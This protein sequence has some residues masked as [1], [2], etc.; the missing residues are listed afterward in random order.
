MNQGT[1]IGGLVAV[2]FDPTGSYLLTVSHSGR[3][4]FSTKTW[5]RLARDYALAYPVDGRAIGI[6]PIEGLSVVV[7]ELDTEHDI[8][9]TSPDGKMKLH[10][11]SSSIEVVGATE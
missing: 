2:G 4:V 9:V 11:Q 1:H 5:E 3:G 8:Y 7:A 10:C 6:G